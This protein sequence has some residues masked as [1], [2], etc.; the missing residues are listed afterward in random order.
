MILNL[1]FQTVTIG[2]GSSSPT[3]T[4]DGVEDPEQVQ[5]AVDEAAAETETKIAPETAADIWTGECVQ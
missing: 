2:P 3:P 1:L 4:T 5:E